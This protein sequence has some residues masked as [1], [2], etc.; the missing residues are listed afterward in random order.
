MKISRANIKRLAAGKPPLQSEAEFTSQVI[1][2]ARR[3]G[4][5][6]AHFRPGMNQ[7]G[8][9][10]TA[11]QGDGAGFP[12]LILIR[13]CRCIVAELKV[14]KNKTTPEQDVWLASFKAA[15]IQAFVWTPD[16]WSTIR[17]EL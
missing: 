3:M 13:G 8:K 6:V 10:M 9:W 15:N 17:A 5:R 7:R 2:W 14:G 11:V 12:D 16:D 1:E 4:W